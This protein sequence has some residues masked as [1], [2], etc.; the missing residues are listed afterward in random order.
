M[1]FSTT[2]STNIMQSEQAD[3]CPENPGQ[4]DMKHLH[5]TVIGLF[6]GP[7]PSW[8]TKFMSIQL[9]INLIDCIVRSKKC[10][11]TYPL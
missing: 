6:S 1:I 2:R 10:E 7:G 8:F 11:T 4:G 9:L 3:P 5:R